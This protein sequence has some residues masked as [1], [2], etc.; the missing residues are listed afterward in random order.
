MRL[1]FFIIL[2]F[3]G[4]QVSVAFH[5]GTLKDTFS[6]SHTL[7]DIESC[8]RKP[9]KSFTIG[10]S[11]YSINRPLDFGYKQLILEFE[12]EYGSSY[13]QNFRICL[14]ID[15]KDSIVLGVLQTLMDSEKPLRSKTFRFNKQKSKIYK[16][17]HEDLYQINFSKGEFKKQITK[18]R[19]YG[20]GC[21]SIG[22]YYPPEALKMLKYVHESHYRKLSHLL[23]QINPE[24]QAYG[25][26]G[27]MKLKKKGII[28]SQEDIKIIEHLK[29]RNTEVYYCSGCL[30]GLSTTIVEILK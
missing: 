17:L 9:F 11:H 5:F 10:S 30:F 20:F 14:L 2:I 22:N 19:V 28:I 21:G 16:S 13:V 27:L 1:L 18:I 24:L 15:S 7:S 8:L 3:V 23:R 6:K 29:K 25:V 4:I 12:I 26:L